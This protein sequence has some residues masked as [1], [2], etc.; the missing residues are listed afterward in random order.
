MYNTAFAGLRMTGCGIVGIGGADEG[1]GESISVRTRSGV[2]G[3]TFAVLALLM[4]VSAC[5]DVGSG[6]SG[7]TALAA[8]VNDAANAG[9]DISAFLNSSAD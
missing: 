8:V 9:T 4:T 5:D 6:G 7:A 3:V 1:I 2:T